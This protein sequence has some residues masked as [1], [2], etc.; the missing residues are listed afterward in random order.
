VRVD[1]G[2]L[3]ER[4][5]VVAAQRRHAQVGDLGEVTMLRPARMTPLWTL[6]RRESQTRVRGFSP[7]SGA[8]TLPPGEPEGWCHLAT[9]EDVP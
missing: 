7:V 8:L 3:Q 6:P 1:L 5:L 4:G 9:E 2:G